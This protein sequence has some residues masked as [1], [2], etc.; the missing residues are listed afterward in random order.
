M[1]IPQ[2][3]NSDSVTPRTSDMTLGKVPCTL[4][5]LTHPFSKTFPFSIT[6]VKPP[7][8]SF[9]FQESFVNLTF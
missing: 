6:I 9:L 4:E 2:A 7:P 3:K 1:L 5:T 8:P